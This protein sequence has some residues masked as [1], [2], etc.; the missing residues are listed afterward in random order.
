M[1]SVLPSTN[2]NEDLSAQLLDEVQQQA[3]TIA[4]VLAEQGD[5]SVSEYVQQLGPSEHSSYQPVSDVADLLLDYVTPLL[6][7]EIAQAARD[8]LM[9]QPLVLTANHHGVDFFA[10]SVQGTLLLSQRELRLEGVTRR[11]RI[12]P[13]F[14]C[15]SVAMNNLTYPRGALLYGAVDEQVPLRLPIFPDR[16]K[17]Q[18]V[19]RT[20]PFDQGMLDR[21]IARVH[22]LAAEGRIT[23]TTQNSMCSILT[24]HYGAREVLTQKSYSDQAVMLNARLWREM[25]PPE[26][27]SELVYLELEEIGARLL[28]QDLGNEQSL[29]SILLFNQTVRAEL[30]TLLNGAKGC[31]VG[32]DLLT[33]ALDGQPLSGFGTFMFWGVDSKG[34]RISLG[35]DSNSGIDVLRAVDSSAAFEPVPLTPESI[36]EA[37]NQGHL[38]PSLFCCYTAISLARGVVCAGG[39]YQAEY[40]PV[41]QQ[42]VVS[43]LRSHGSYSDIVAKVERVKTNCYLSGMQMVMANDSQAGLVPAGPVEIIAGGG[44]SMAELKQL[45]QLSVRLA[46]IA[47]LSETV[48]DVVPD[49]ILSASQLTRLARE[50]AM[51]QKDGLIVK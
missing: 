38:L 48:P 29:I 4:R 12:V 40:L 30:M 47:S 31:W 32:A 2:V 21:A 3:S 9:T 8:E 13:V 10:Q 14:A 25:M 46:H 22:K 1:N 39:Y 36:T 44:L 43:A 15:G 19:A 35:V 49:Q 6:G 41:M 42:G 20:A 5:C 51:R 34:R 26:S 50:I 17:R 18:L 24:E 7:R 11:A 37:M 23:S 45:G 27:D 33:Q 16:V 28:Q